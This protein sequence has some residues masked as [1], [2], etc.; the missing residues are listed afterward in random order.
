M[1]MKKIVLVETADSDLGH[2][3]DMLARSDLK[4]FIASSGIAAL[5]LHK[6]EKADLIII[7]LDMPDIKGEAFCERLR[8]DDQLK[9]VSVMIL[10]GNMKSE[11][12]RAS[13]CGANAF[14]TTPIQAIE[15]FSKVSRL[16]NVQS[17]GSY[18]VLVKV[19]VLG[20]SDAESFFC[21]SIN[22]SITGMLIEAAKPLSKGD[23]ILCS[24]FLPG[25][26]NITTEAEVVRI[27]NRD[28]GPT[29]YGIRFAGMDNKCRS[30]LE[31][32]VNHRTNHN[33]T[34]HQTIHTK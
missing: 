18:R 14:V 8:R 24:F 7:G 25:R 28:S 17:R 19:S 2:E 30:A 23:L 22:I 31:E 1:T 6:T 10:C 20:N 12:E 9:K 13:L 15:F 21:S 11:I 3:K 29:Q 27:V 33:Q 4:L 5:E 16:I 26:N 32:F 34:N